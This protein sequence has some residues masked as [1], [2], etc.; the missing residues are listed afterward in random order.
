MATVREYFDADF[1]YA[2]RVHVRLPADA[3]SAEVAVLYDFSA[4]TAFL[5]CYVPGDRHTLKE[6][7]Q[8]IDALKPGN[9]VVFPEG[10]VTLPSARTF[11]GRLTFG[12]GEGFEIRAQFDGDNEWIS[13]R[14][15]PSSSRVFIYSESRLTDVEI[16]QLKQTGRE[17]D[18]RVQFRI[19]RAR[20]GALTA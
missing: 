8:L 12:N 3:S 17:I 5:S 2:T 20:R 14:E 6:F 13:T 7:Q 1:S 16:S 18:L 15:I 11:P 10:K 19:C 9:Q 4:F